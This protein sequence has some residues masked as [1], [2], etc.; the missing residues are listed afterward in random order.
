M[1][2]G[3]TSLTLSLPKDWTNRFGLK[4]G[5]EIELEEIDTKI[6]ISSSNKKK[7]EIK[8]LDYS[9]I[10][11]NELR[12]YVVAVYKSGIKDI[13][14]ENIPSKYLEK[15][16]IVIKNLAGLEIIE[17]SKNSLRIL[18]ISSTEEETITK[19][20]N[21][22]YW[23]LENMIEKVIENKSS[24]EEIY[25]IDM[26]INR[27][28]FFAMRNISTKFSSSPETFIRYEKISLLEEL[29]D[30]I[31][32]YNKNS[33][34]EDSELNLLEKLQP[35]IE[36]T[37]V[38]ESKREMP[39]LEEINKKIKELKEKVNLKEKNTPL[40]KIFLLEVF[41]KFETVVECLIAINLKDKLISNKKTA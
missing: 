20:E 38:F 32:T 35:L 39:P 24:I 27:L 26:E 25:A 12:A 23:K 21:Q 3:P 1:K 8:S 13:Y 15:V 36:K 33:K 29:G 4:K 9:Q 31:R 18:D 2:H 17:S 34:K 30:A 7:T 16:K 5:D 22:I 10:Q 11:E 19:S 40:G 28:A 41:D 37:R 6:L 14:L